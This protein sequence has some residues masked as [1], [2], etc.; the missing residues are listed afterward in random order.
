LVENKVVLYEKP[1]ESEDII[2]SD[3][4]IIAKNAFIEDYDNFIPKTQYNYN[5]TMAN[6]LYGEDFIVEIIYYVVQR[7]LRNIIDLIE[8]YQ[9][10]IKVAG[11]MLIL[12][13]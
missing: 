13:C 4:E 3:E 7:Y 10:K 11:C 2:L 5:L 8:E 9:K 1:S 12:M 6:R